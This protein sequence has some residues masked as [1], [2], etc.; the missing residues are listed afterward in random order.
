MSVSL[1]MIIM[2][3]ITVKVE[4]GFYKEYILSC[5]YIITILSFKTDNIN[6]NAKH[7][8]VQ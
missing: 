7:T 2:I 4:Y 6:F 5:H 3:I 8:H 1:A